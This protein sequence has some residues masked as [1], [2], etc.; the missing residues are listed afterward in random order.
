MGEGERDAQPCRPPEFGDPHREPVNRQAWVRLGRT[1]RRALVSRW[2]RT[3]EGLV[4]H[5]VYEDGDRQNAGYFTYDPSAIRPGS[6]Q[7]FGLRHVVAYLSLRL[8]V[9]Q[10]SAAHTRPKV[11]PGS[12]SSVMS[13][14]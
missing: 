9:L 6:W 5:L 12:L 4:L 11:N 14:A 2:W 13:S 8:V 3:R 10:Y 1:W 7:L